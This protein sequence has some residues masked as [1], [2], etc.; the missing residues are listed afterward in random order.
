MKKLIMIL[1]SLCA[2]FTISAKD[3]EVAVGAGDRFLAKQNPQVAIWLED[4]NGAFVKTL[5]VSNNGAD[6]KT[7]LPVFTSV[8]KNNTKV[9]AETTSTPKGGFNFFISIP[10]DAVY[11]M[12]AEVNAIGDYNKNYTK[13]TTGTSGQPSVVYSG[14]V[15]GDFPVEEVNLLPY[16]VG[17]AKGANGKV[18]EDLTKLTTAQQIFKAFSI[19]A[20]KEE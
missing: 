19:V 18:S 2:V 4:T 12:K 3:L 16:G 8:A 20:V 1:V 17:D 15:R 5:Y 7:L 6:T 10:D 9:D 11:I 14:E 13:S